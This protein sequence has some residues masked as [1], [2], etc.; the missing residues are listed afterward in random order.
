MGLCSQWG[1]GQGPDVTPALALLVALTPRG[2]DEM[3]LAEGIQQQG[4]ILPFF[5]PKS[6]TQGQPGA[7]P[8]FRLIFLTPS[9]HNK[10]IFFADLQCVPAARGVPEAPSPCR[11]VPSGPSLAV[12]CS[13]F[14]FQPHGVQVSPEPGEVFLCG[15]TL[16]AGGRAYRSRNPHVDAPFLGNFYL[17]ARSCRCA[18][19]HWDSAVPS[20]DGGQT[21]DRKEAFL[22]EKQQAPSSLPLHILS[23][24]RGTSGCVPR[25]P[26]TGTTFPLEEHVGLLSL[27]HFAEGL[28]QAHSAPKLMWASEISLIFFFLAVK[29]QGSSQE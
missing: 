17:S 4:P 12:G 5:C 23:Q 3:T 26:R 9:A 10:C 21:C 14:Q 13:W 25:C 2:Q 27:L 6:T 28:S 8:D 19:R 18:P 7:Q 16:G 1:V 11:F 20:G 22:P 15:E 24:P 29:A